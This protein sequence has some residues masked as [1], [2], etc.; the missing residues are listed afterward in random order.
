MS[1]SAGSPGNPSAG[2]PCV[3]IT[4]T[5]CL[6]LTWLELWEFPA[7]VIQ[8]QCLWLGG[9]SPFGD[10]GGC[11]LLPG[12]SPI[13]QVPPLWG[14]EGLSQHRSKP[15]TTSAPSEHDALPSLDLG[16]VNPCTTIATSC[17]V[18]LVWSDLH[19]PLSG[20]E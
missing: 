1:I 8:G 19:S 15:Q 12:D 14:L 13:A 7:E 17:W 2:K 6:Q 20:K 5:P 3:T 4:N 10:H 9:N 11:H 16:A 18:T